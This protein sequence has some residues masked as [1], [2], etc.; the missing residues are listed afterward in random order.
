MDFPAPEPRREVSV[1][2]RFFGLGIFGCAVIAAIMIE[3]FGSATTQSYI[4][5][6]LGGALVLGVVLPMLLF[7]R[8]TRY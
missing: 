6:M 1:G 3:K 7:R 5:P 8:L 2:G 4:L